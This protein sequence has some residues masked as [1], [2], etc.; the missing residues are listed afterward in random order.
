MLKKTYLML[1]AIILLSFLLS[2][3]LASE[4]GSDVQVILT[5]LPSNYPSYYLRICTV[6]GTEQLLIGEQSIN[7]DEVYNQVFHIKNKTEY[8]VAYL[9]ANKTDATP[10]YIWVFQHDKWKPTQTSQYWLDY[11]SYLK[12]QVVFGISVR[13]A[14]NVEEIRSLS[15]DFQKYPYRLLRVK[16]AKGSSVDIEIHVGYGA[17]KVSYSDNINTIEDNEQTY[18]QDTAL[19]IP[20]WDS[21]QDLYIL[22]KPET[23]G[24]GWGTI[25]VLVNSQNKIDGQMVSVIPGNSPDIM[26]AIQRN[27]SGNAD[28]LNYIDPVNSSI[29]KDFDLPAVPAFS[30]LAYSAGDQKLYLAG[31]NEI[32]VWDLTTEQLTEFNVDATQPT[33]IKLDAT[34]RKIYVA[35]SGKILILNMDNPAEQLG[36]KDTGVVSKLL[37]DSENGRLY[38]LNDNHLER[39]TINANTLS[40]DGTYAN[41]VNDIVLRP[42][43]EAIYVAESGTRTLKE[44]S[45]TDFTQVLYLLEMAGDGRSLAVT[46]YE[47]NLFIFCMS[48]ESTA[49]GSSTLYIYLSRSWDGRPLR[50]MAINDTKPSQLISNSNGSI[51]VDVNEGYLRFLEIDKIAS[52]IA[53][54]SKSNITVQSILDSY[55]SLPRK[56]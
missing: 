2:G 40:E 30:T 15:I 10:Q 41:L 28:K 31:N 13:K 12:D 47:S 42:N 38:I 37:L 26:Y 16:N 44:I 54:E 32:G 5:D 6:E 45:A 23:L 51:L 9:F 17:L 22:L 55:A 48:A 39:L 33:A 52:L 20:K 24:S 8:I 27:M 14:F 25:T 19:N 53:P 18:S 43:K 3:C 1:G 49:D 21:D 11:Q 4:N 46:P 36:A 7:S 35:Y 29:S 56:F 34:N 50:K